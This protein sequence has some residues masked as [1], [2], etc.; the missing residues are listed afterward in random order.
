MGE[1]SWSPDVGGYK[2]T[3]LQRKTPRNPKDPLFPKKFNF[4]L[5]GHL[6]SEMTQKFNFFEKLNF[7]GLLAK[8]I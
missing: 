3:A 2:T 8:F 4:L 6:S 5:W 7:W 1:P